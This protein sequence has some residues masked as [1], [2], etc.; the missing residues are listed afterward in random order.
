MEKDQAPDNPVDN[1]LRIQIETRPLFRSVTCTIWLDVGPLVLRVRGVRR[2]ALPWDP[3]RLDLPAISPSLEQFDLVSAAARRL[4][5]T[6]RETFG[7]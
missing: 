6:Y 5:A 7:S 2:K 1:P 3:P 4:F